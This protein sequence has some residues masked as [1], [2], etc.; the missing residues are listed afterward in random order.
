MTNQS[1]VPVA[2]AA[3]VRRWEAVARALLDTPGT[4]NDQW[5]R[6]TRWVVVPVESASHFDADDA[7]RLAR[8]AV[9]QGCSTLHAVAAEPLESFP[10]CFR[11]AASPEGLLTF[12]RE[13][14][15]FNFVLLPDK[16]AFAVLCTVY[17]YFLVAG[18]VDFARAAGGDVEEARRRFRRFAEEHDQP[19][20]LLAVA[21]ACETTAPGPA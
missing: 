4:F 2:D 20:R 5:L 8:A 14:A 21:R 17:D 15:H 3:E 19:D 9:E 13:C 12:S 10:R 6:H 7:D 18:P 16:Y 1:L 11:V